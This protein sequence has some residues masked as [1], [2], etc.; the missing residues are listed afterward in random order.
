MTLA[1]FSPPIIQISDCASVLH[2]WPARVWKYTPGWIYI[3]IAFLVAKQA[4]ALSFKY[5]QNKPQ[6]IWKKYAHNSH[7]SVEYHSPCG[8][9]G[10]RTEHA[11]TPC[12]SPYRFGK[13]ARSICSPIRLMI[14]YLYLLFYF[15]CTATCCTSWWQMTVCCECD[16]DVIYCTL[17]FH[18]LKNV[19]FSM[20]VTS[21][22]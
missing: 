4:H 13:K 18:Y 11:F 16:T 21:G 12:P 5:P 7:F 20:A 15:C 10:K 3:C 22:I 19:T 6:I 2:V 9:P 17:E 1:I 8:R 14:V